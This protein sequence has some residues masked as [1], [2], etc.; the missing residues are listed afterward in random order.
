MQATV[1]N[2]DTLFSA[3]HRTEYKFVINGVDYLAS[4]LQGIPVITKPLLDVPTIGRVCSATLSLVVRPKPNVSI[5]KAATVNAYCRL[6]NDIIATPWVEQGKFFVSSRTVKSNIT[7]SCRDAMIKTGQTYLDKTAL[8]FP[9]SQLT[10]LNEILSLMGVTLDSRTTIKTGPEYMVEDISDDTLMSEVLANIAACNGGNWVMT[11]QGKLRLIPFQTH[12]STALQALGF[13]YK[14]Y[15][16]SGNP[17]IITRVTMVDNS[18]TEYTAG[19]DIGINSRIVSVNDVLTVINSEEEKASISGNNL[20]IEEDAAYFSG[21]SLLVTNDSSGYEIYLN[22]DYANQTVVNALGNVS[23]ASGGLYNAIYN[24]CRC[25]KMYLNPLLEAGDCISITTKNS[26]TKKFRLNALSISCN[27][28]YTCTNEVGISESAEDEYPYETM[29]ELT[30]SRNVRTDQKYYGNSITRKDGFKSQLDNGAYAIFNADELSFVDE[31]GKKCLYYDAETRTFKVCAVITGRI[32]DNSGLSYWDLDTGEM[33]ISSGAKVSGDI[34]MQDLVDQVDNA[35]QTWYQ[36]S[37]PSENWSDTEKTEHIGDLWYRTTDNTT[38]RW[39]GLLWNDQD[40]PDEIF[41]K[42]DG[43]SSIYISQPTPP[44]EVG[45]L[46]A[47]GSTGELY[48]CEQGR[49]IGQFQQN[50]WRLACKYTDDSSLEDFID[51]TYAEDLQELK[52]EL[53]DKIE[54]WYQTSD[55]SIAWTTV[56]QQQAHTG[57]IWYNS[58]QSSQKTYRWNGSAWVEQNISKSVLDKIDGKRAIF[59]GDT[60]PSNPEE[61][62]LWVKNNDGDIWIYTNGNWVF[63]NDIDIEV[64]GRN[65]IL[66]SNKDVSGSKHAITC[67]RYDLA[68]VVQNGMVYTWSANVSYTSG[69]QSIAL[70]FGNTCAS[71]IPLG[72][73]GTVKVSAEFTASLAMT[74]ETEINIKAVDT[75]TSAFVHTDLSTQL[76]IDSESEQH[77]AYLGN[78]LVLTNGSETAFTIINTSGIQLQ[79]KTGECVVNWI[80]LETGKTATD[81][82]AAPEDVDSAILEA[83]DT[84]IKSAKIG[85]DAANETIANV[86]EYVN[87]IKDELEQTDAKLYDNINVTNAIKDHV[88]KWTYPD[89]VKIDGGAIQARTID[90][91]A[92]HAENLSAISADLGLITAGKIQSEDGTLLIDFTEAGTKGIQVI[93]PEGTG[94]GTSLHIDSDGTR[95]Y[96]GE[97]MGTVVAQFI[98]TG[99]ECQEIKAEVGEVGGLLITKV[100]NGAWFSTAT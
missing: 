88:G 66:Q 100:E 25:E 7:L 53:A 51:T 95:V 80:K 16:E 32:Q 82:T 2:W 1:T 73:S 23:Y 89:T 21:A 13:S 33:R 38:H 64:G 58:T 40:V 62:D 76:C 14:S 94:T 12:E 68:R 28:G 44:Y 46:W 81:W 93:S 4:D 98:S 5:P 41:D 55:P 65:L 67:A 49:E 85:I 18:K 84:A 50:D 22:N 39:N 3:S 72:S 20:V 63:C 77:A 43:K 19:D 92:L 42:I 34:T 61:N 26:Q 45:D 30:A 71:I 59:Y 36:S 54:T 79:N 97:N 83:Q 91:E 57:D 70:Y 86:V 48:R 74:P 15:T 27:V 69:R 52:D 35:V 78:T 10:V 96:G 29:A 31:S 87:S 56:E 37:D 8:E 9:K 99:V 17:K 11:E 47:Q 6:T 90:V 75:S 60:T 24:P